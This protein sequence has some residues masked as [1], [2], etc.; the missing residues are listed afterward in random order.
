MVMGKGS[1]NDL[2]SSALLTAGKQNGINILLLFHPLS[3]QTLG[4]PQ[5][6]CLG[7][8]RARQLMKKTCEAFL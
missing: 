5:I 8:T 1:R 6:I 4:F 7:M 2:F 3:L